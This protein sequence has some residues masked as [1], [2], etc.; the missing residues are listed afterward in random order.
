M[1]APLD[2]TT[3]E[4]IDF[5]DCRNFDKYFFSLIAE[6]HTH[7][8]AYELLE[9]EHKRIFKKRKYKNFESY[10]IAKHRRYKG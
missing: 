6:N 4:I 3:Q 7:E 10:R 9:A 5:S 2:L 8:E 1:K